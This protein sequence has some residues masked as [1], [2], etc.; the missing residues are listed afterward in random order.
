M[1]KKTSQIWTMS[2]CSHSHNA[3]VFHKHTLFLMVR[4]G[5]LNFNSKFLTPFL[6]L[7]DECAN[8]IL[9]DFPLRNRNAI[10]HGIANKLFSNA[11]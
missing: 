7:V 9:R 4:F 1:T 6:K 5:F 2:M 3:L 8:R 10:I 11:S